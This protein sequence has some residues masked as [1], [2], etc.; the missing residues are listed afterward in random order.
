MF[1][2]LFLYKLGLLDQGD[3]NGPNTDCHSANPDCKNQPHF[4]GI[5]TPATPSQDMG[6]PAK[7]WQTANA[8]GCQAADLGMQE[9]G[10]QSSEFVA[11]IPPSAK[12]HKLIS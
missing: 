7:S 6:D 9:D 12:S 4:E 5:Q 11:V 2:H 1:F 8:C 10:V 3:L